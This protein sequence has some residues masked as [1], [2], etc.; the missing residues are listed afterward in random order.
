MTEEQLDLLKFTTGC[1]A[2]LCARATQVMRR[3][4]RNTDLAS[5]LPEHLPNDLLAQTL[6]RNNT[7]TV[8]GP[9]DAAR[10]DIASRCPRVDRH[11]CPSRH[12]RSSNAPVLSDKVDDA[13]APVALLNV[14]D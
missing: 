2:E 11:L 13:P 4:S 3:D 7:R 8:Y 5:I 1:S 6:A 12:R 14:R 10:S 9:E